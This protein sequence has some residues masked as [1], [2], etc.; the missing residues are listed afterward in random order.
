Q[1]VSE[2]AACPSEPIKRRGVEISYS[3]APG[4]SNDG[5]RLLSGDVDPMPAECP[6]A[7][8]EYRHPQGRAP[9]RACLEPRHICRLH[10]SIAIGYYIKLQRV[11]RFQVPARLCRSGWPCMVIIFGSIN[12]DVT[13]PVPSLP[14]PGETVLGGDYRLVPGG[15]GA[16]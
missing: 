10:H 3:R 13:I 1:R 16:N 2:D 15:K 4:G 11:A 12:F 9:Q 8:A 6:G 5:L 7:E 14:Q